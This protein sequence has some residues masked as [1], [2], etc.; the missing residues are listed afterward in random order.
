M[1]QDAQGLQ[2][3]Q[4]NMQDAEE[5]AQRPKHPKPL[6]PSTC[7]YLYKGLE[8]KVCESGAVTHVTA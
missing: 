5:Y 8:L 4:D 6:L 7:D 2:Y 3:A 1:F